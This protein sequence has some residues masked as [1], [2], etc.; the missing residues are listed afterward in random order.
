MLTSIFIVS[1]DEGEK[2]QFLSFLNSVPN[3][4]YL[5]ACYE[6]TVHKFE[7]KKLMNFL[8]EIFLRLI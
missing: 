7:K 3:E 8:K 1:A 4:C 2:N 6:F 5:T